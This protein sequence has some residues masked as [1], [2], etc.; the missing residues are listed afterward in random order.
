MNSDFYISFYFTEILTAVCLKILSHP[1]N[2]N[3]W[4]VESRVTDLNLSVLY[5]TTL[6]NLIQKR[7]VETYPNLTLI[8]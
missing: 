7:T 1:D 5:F 2:I 3:P 6:L 4:R 8:N